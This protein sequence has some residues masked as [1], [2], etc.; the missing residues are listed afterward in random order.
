MVPLILEP[1][2]LKGNDENVVVITLQNKV[3]HN[4]FSLMK[5]LSNVVITLQNNRLQ[6]LK[7][8][9][10]VVITLQNKVF[11][12]MAKIFDYYVDVV[13]TLQNKVFHNLMET[14]PNGTYLKLRC[15]SPSK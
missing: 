2:L 9:A 3:F 4:I 8:T 15:N 13:I 1:L 5:E 10:T 11:H 12:N 7:P 6:L 14:Y